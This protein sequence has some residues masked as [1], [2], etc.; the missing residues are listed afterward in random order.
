MAYS[1]C[2]GLSTRHSVVQCRKG[3]QRKAGF[4]S[5]LPKVNRGLI[6][7]VHWAALSWKLGMDKKLLETQGFL[8]LPRKKTGGTNNKYCHKNNAKPLHMRRPVAYLQL[9]LTQWLKETQFLKLF[10]DVQCGMDA[11]LIQ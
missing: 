3:K 4:C 11:I 9:P 6:T 10:S 2:Q 5:I 1:F 8:S 7:L